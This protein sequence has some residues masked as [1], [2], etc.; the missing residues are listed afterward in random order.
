MGAHQS[1][2]EALII[3]VLWGVILGIIVQVRKGSYWF[4][5]GVLIFIWTTS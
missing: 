1:S 4:V 5:G 3:F 2:E